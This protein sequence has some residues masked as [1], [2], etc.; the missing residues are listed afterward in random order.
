MACYEP[1]SHM[2]TDRKSRIWYCCQ[3]GDGPYALWTSTCKGC[4]HTISPN[5]LS[6]SERFVLVNI[7]ASILG[8][9]RLERVVGMM[10]I[11]LLLVLFLSGLVSN[12]YAQRHH[13][14]PT[15]QG[16]NLQAQ[17]YNT[18]LAPLLGSAVNPTHNSS[19]YIRTPDQICFVP[20]SV[21]SSQYASNMRVHEVQNLR[22]DEVPGVRYSP[23]GNWDQKQQL[24]RRSTV[25]GR[26]INHTVQAQPSP[27]TL[28]II[29]NGL[30][31]SGDCNVV[32]GQ[33]S[34]GFLAAVV[35]VIAFAFSASV[36][37]IVD[38]HVLNKVS[39]FMGIVQTAVIWCS[40]GGD[41]EFAFLVVLPWC[42]WVPALIKSILCVCK[43]GVQETVGKPGQCT[44]KSMMRDSRVEKAHCIHDN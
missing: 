1:T 6:S 11:G 29:L 25:S 21:Y 8:K 3:C 33:S 40:I 9:F 42:I 23:P 28:R 10:K 17:R 35:S 22:A 43:A 2:S 5:G 36:L 4:D 7:P 14:D 34:I 13:R 37:Q 38:P 15:I 31:W 30:A 19:F 39:I 26:S 16:Y 27:Q 44:E 24:L 41:L 18:S 32:T 20:S 12:K